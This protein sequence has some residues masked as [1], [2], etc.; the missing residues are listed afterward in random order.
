MTTFL[1]NQVTAEAADSG[2]DAE[3]SNRNSSSASPQISWQLGADT[4]IGG[5]RENQD[6]YLIWQKPSLGICVICIF[7]G[8]GREVGKIASGAA[9]AS[10]QRFCEESVTEL[11]ANP[12][13]WLIKAH[14]NAHSHIKAVFK[15]ELERQGYEVREAPEGY[16]LKRKMLSMQWT[17]VHGGSSS[18]IVAIVGTN[19]YI[20][21]VGDSTA[22]LCTAAPVLNRTILKHLTD[23]AIVNLPAL[24]TTQTEVFSDEEA[25]QLSNTLP[26]TAEHSPES[27]HEFYRLRAYRSR[28]ADTTQ[29]SLLIVYDAPSVEK[30][31]CNPVFELNGKGVPCVTNRGRYYKNVRKEWA[32]LVSTPVTARFQDAL[33]F[34]RS[35]GDLHLHTYGKFLLVKLCILS[36][37]V[38]LCTSCEMLMVC[39]LPGPPYPP[40]A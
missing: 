35:L 5:G 11:Q 36:F 7:D 19:M 27:V 14:V 17:C 4:D 33:A 21:N 16:L 10:V 26:I 9:K 23:A 30:A 32:S 18:S 24:P 6:D 1:D 2:H 3:N 39:V 31:R 38:Y 28:D 15:T 12:S 20:A 25:R 29:P 34:T 13:N 8:H 37:L 40:E 22:T